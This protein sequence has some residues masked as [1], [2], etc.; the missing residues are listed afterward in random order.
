MNKNCET[1]VDDSGIEILVSYWYEKSKSQVEEGHGF[2]EVGLMVY[3][4]LV[5]VE[6]VIAGRGIELIK[7]LTENEKEFIIS[8][9]TYEY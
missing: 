2:H 7:E 4:E 1:I 5:S 8:K 9:L 6:L 3:T